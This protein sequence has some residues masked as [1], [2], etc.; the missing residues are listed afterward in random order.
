MQS[1]FRRGLPEKS[2]GFTLTEVAIVLVVIAILVGGLMGPM[3]RYIDQQ[4]F[5]ATQTQLT[6]VRE[7]LVAY[8]A[9]NGRLPCP[10]YYATAANSGGIEVIGVA[11][12][13]GTAGMPLGTVANNTG[14]WVG[15]VPARTL[16]LSPLDQDGFLLDAWGNRMRYAVV[17]RMPAATAAP[18]NVASGF[19]TATDNLFTTKNG[20]CGTYA[21]TSERTWNAVSSYLALSYTP[22]ATNKGLL[23]VCRAVPPAGMT[24]LRCGNPL[25]NTPSTNTETDSAPAVVYSVGQQAVSRGADEAENLNL[26]RIFINHTPSD[27]TTNRYDD[28]VA[29]V[30]LNTLYAKMLSAGQLC[31]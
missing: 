21:P 30:S 7:A 26:D 5:N 9:A 6:S 13:C 14:A 22:G 25:G 18:Y 19:N 8:A 10:A 24:G 2:H 16:G 11:N 12:G 23:H 29:W 4:R 17:N 3:F 31:P 28:L 20:L 27:M 15:F 1:A